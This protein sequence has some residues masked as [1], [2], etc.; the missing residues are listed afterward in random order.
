METEEKPEGARMVVAGRVEELRLFEACERALARAYAEHARQAVGGAR[1]F[2]LTE[3][4]RRDAE[5]L[6]ARILELGGDARVEPDD[7]WIMGPTDELGTLL[8]AEHQAVRTYRDHLLDLDPESMMLVRD[9][10]LPHHERTLEELT[11]ERR[12][13]L[14][15]T[16]R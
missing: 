11:G 15:P 4:R 12:R 14:G 7:L 3:R 6:A 10:I 2:Y 5:L 16:G 8:F 13:S 1:F 9:H